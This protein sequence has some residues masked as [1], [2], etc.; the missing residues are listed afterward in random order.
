M[1]EDIPFYRGIFASG[2]GRAYALAQAHL[3][4]DGAP[5]RW[6]GIVRFDPNSLPSAHTAA[7]CLVNA[8]SL[9]V[10]PIAPGTIMTLFGERMGP[11]TGASFALQD[12]H[13]PFNI[14]GA[15]ITVDGRPAPVLYA[16]AGQINFIA[17]WSLRTDGTRV[18]ICV[19]MNTASSCLYAATAP[20]SPGLFMVNSQIAAINPDGTI[21]SRIRRRQTRVSV[22]FDGH[23]AINGSTVD[24]GSGSDLQRYG[25]CRG[26]LHRNF[27]G[28]IV[29]LKNSGR[30]CSLRWCRT[31]AGI[32]GERGHCDVIV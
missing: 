11:E 16:Q 20:I 22:Y 4:L 24:G 17:P 32:W 31:D 6:Q 13:V 3:V 10:A 27:P 19:V 30:P 12:G 2:D 28:G 8:A 23:G 14:A 5:T 18:P 29:C 26:Q 1:G 7:G 9:L 25:R 21:N 15:S